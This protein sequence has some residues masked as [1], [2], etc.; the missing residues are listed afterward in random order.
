MFGSTNPESTRAAAPVPQAVCGLHLPPN[1]RKGHG[2]IP[3]TTES[4]DPNE[5]LQSAKPWRSSF[6]TLR[7]ESK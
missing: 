6:N 7:K 1:A 4:I 5:G 3:G 2:S